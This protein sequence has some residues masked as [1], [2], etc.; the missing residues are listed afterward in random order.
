MG[1]DG[2]Q[3]FL[4]LPSTLM[5][6]I[7]PLTTTRLDY[8][9]PTLKPYILTITLNPGQII[10]YSFNGSANDN[11]VDGEG[12]QIVAYEWSS[13]LDGVLSTSADFARLS[14]DLSRGTHT[15]SLKAKDN[16]GIWSESVT[17]EL[18]VEHPLSV[19]RIYCLC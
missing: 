5:A 14:I 6:K 11:D 1:F 9:W 4:P 13:N 19:S 16:E 10:L 2:E 12:E 3:E 7:R 17:M 15:I 18:I 8:P